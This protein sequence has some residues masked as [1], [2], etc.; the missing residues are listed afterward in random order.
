[1][2]SQVC[3]E[4]CSNAGGGFNKIKQ[5]KE[6]LNSELDFTLDSFEVNRTNSRVLSQLP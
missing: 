4:S 3:T 1:M 5:M 2:E 6:M